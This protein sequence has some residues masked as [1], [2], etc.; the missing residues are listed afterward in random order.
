M[1]YLYTTIP[2]VEIF[3]SDLSSAF[4]KTDSVLEV[5]EEH[6]YTPWYNLSL[7]R[8]GRD[9]IK[10]LFLPS[11][12]ILSQ[13]RA[14]SEES[15]TFTDSLTTELTIQTS[16]INLL[17]SRGAYPLSGIFFETE[18]LR[19]EVSYS[20]TQVFSGADDNEMAV[21]IDNY[22]F[23][24]LS[25]V[26]SFWLENQFS[27]DFVADALDNIGTFTWSIKQ[28]TLPN[29]KFLEEKLFD[30][31]FIIHSE[32]IEYNLFTDPGSEAALYGSSFF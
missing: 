4:N 20:S 16:A 7:I 21:S 15:G 3:D 11:T 10:D 9:S 22:F 12:V 6:T 14:L 1:D 2:V 28:Q 31:A 27:W 19:M 18:E 30:E 26:N 29:W 24:R 23:F 17:G 5:L 8:S 13:S 25:E 32:E